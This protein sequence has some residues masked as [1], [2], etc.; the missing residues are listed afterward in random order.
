MIAT[1]EDIRQ[2]VV[3]KLTKEMRVESTDV[4][5]SVADGY[6]VTLTG[7]VPSQ[8]LRELMLRDA[9]AVPGVSAIVDELAL[10]VANG[11]NADRTITDGVARALEQSDC[12]ELDPYAIEVVANNGTVTLEGMAPSWTAIRAAIAAARQTPGVISVREQIL[13]QP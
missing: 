4:H 1:Q 13:L 11:A 8:R 9:S 3:D 10:G 5:V 12:L 2:D 6:V 7:T